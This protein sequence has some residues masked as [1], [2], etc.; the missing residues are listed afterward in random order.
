MLHLGFLG[1]ILRVPMWA[2]LGSFFWVLH[3]GSTS[4]ILNPLQTRSV[5]GIR[6]RKFVGENLEPNMKPANPKSADIRP[7]SNLLPSLIGSDN[8]SPCPHK[9]FHRF[10][11]PARDIFF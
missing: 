2:L 8:Y 9:N 1:Y 11:W 3:W 7:K 5:S 6:I 4:E 10:D